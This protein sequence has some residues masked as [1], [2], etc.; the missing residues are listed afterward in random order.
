MINE[1]TDALDGPE[2]IANM[3]Q[4]YAI[5]GDVNKS[6]DSLSKAL[7]IP[8]RLSPLWIA[9]DPAWTPLRN[10]L[11]FKSLAAPVWRVVALRTR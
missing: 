2:W 10:D 5:L 6:V 4:V 1:A 9:L 7:R 3:A 11:R 8:S